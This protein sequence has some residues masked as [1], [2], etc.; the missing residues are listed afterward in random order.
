VPFWRKKAYDRTEL[1][2]AADRARAQGRRRRAIRGYR[3]VLEADPLDHVV[4]G[5]LAP[6]L[7]QMKRRGE[8][9]ASFELAAQGQLKA[10]FTDR[11]LAMY[12]QAASHFPEEASLWEE[13]ARLEHMRGRRADAVQALIEGGRELG[14]RAELRPI[15]VRLLKSALDLEPWHPPAT[16][17]LARLLVKERERGEALA[18]LEDLAQRVRGPARR[19]A[20]GAILRLAPTPGNAWLWLRAA[21]RGR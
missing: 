11:A 10:G 13:I 2:A 6:V 5:K 1:L 17:A 9:L 18:L 4:H 15:G 21:L 14:R 20:R 3:K 8:A 19:R 12:V 16:M 7:A